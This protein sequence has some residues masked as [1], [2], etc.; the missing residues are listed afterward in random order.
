[1]TG[2]ITR[3]D[4]A[5][6]HATRSSVPWIAC[7]ALS[8]L[9]VLSGLAL[10][11]GAPGPVRPNLLLVTVDSLRGDRLACYGG[12][13][14]VGTVVCGL[15]KHGT[16]Y[17]WAIS[18]SPFTSVAIASI[19]TSSY[20]S[21]HGM[22][23]TASS[24]LR[25]PA[26]TLAEALHSGGYVSGAFVGNPSLNRSS[27]LQQGFDL[28]DDRPAPGRTA[29]PDGQASSARHGA[30]ELTQAALAF[31]QKAEEAEQPWFVWVH[32][33]EARGPYRGVEGGSGDSPPARHAG[34]S[35]STALI[36]LAD[37][38]GRSGVPAYQLPATA[39]S[40]RLNPWPD[41]ES[42]DLLR[43]Y[44]AEI[45]GI[46][47]QIGLLIAG[48]DA[49]GRP[50][51]IVTA[52][53]GEALGE[54]D[55]W[56]AHGHSVALEQIWVPLVWRPPHELG[57]ASAERWDRVVHEPVSTLDIAPTL[58]T[59]AGLHPPAHFAGVSLDAGSG[60][61]SSATRRR[62]FAE[63]PLRA[64]VVTRGVYYARD[65]WPL[66]EPVRDPLRGGTLHA[67]PTRFARLGS[68]GKPT[69]YRLA[70]GAS[71]PEAVSDPGIAELE[72]TLAAFLSRSESG[73]SRERDAEP[74]SAQLNA[75][76]E[77]QTLQELQ[78]SQARRSRRS[79]GPAGSAD[80]S[81]PSVARAVALA[82]ALCLCACEA[83]RPD[84]VLVTLDTLRR[85]HVGLYGDTRGL[86]PQLDRLAESGL[87]HDA[88]FTTMPTTGPAHL[89]LF[90]GLYPSVIGAT[91]NAE[92]LPDRHATRELTSLL[93]A[94]GY[95]TAAFV[96]SWLAGSY[97][98]GLRG[99]AVYDEP[100][101]VLRSGSD[102]V[103]AALDWLAIEEPRPIFLWVHIYD[104]H[105][106]YG[107]T[108]QKRLGFPLDPRIYGWT[109][110][111]HFASG[112]VT[113]RMNGLYEDGVREADDELGRLL[114]GVRELR[115]QP[116]GQAPVIIVVSDHGESLGEH[117]AT[118][119]YSYD[120]GEFLDP[121]AVRIA[122][123]LAGPGIPAERSSGAVS[124]RD[125]YTTILETAGLGDAY[126][127]IEGRR[128]LRYT[129][130]APRIVEFER[131]SFS[132]PQPAMVEA[133]AGGASDGERI[134][135]AGP[136]GKPTSGAG[137][138]SDALL[139]AASSRAKQAALAARETPPDFAPDTIEALK[140][141][142]YAP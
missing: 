54:D 47:Q 76:P 53:H 111:A 62:I 59:A 24:G 22:T 73:G 130:A 122:L 113:K 14:G 60:P 10:A 79:L 132:E 107:D 30:A 128:D 141:L 134:V 120:H 5:P 29:S 124:I 67:I 43:G 3:T 106:P 40:E 32:Y 93:V 38:S 25:S 101:S 108:N 52:D 115:S 109:D 17:S 51:V 12:P 125:L 84:I 70:A 110:A 104:A 39:P 33:G 139:A 119:G 50:G 1:M 95:A 74:G 28:Y 4:T 97:G 45:R 136:D 18:P 142:G 85:D 58:L 49:I 8:A 89:S 133:H 114:A 103:D 34:T 71:G 65:R 2:A 15:A 140:A 16:R 46:D 55:Y 66:T 80:R 126:A 68:D 121:E 137:G 90:T 23:A 100:S 27:N 99:F 20:P 138:A 31:A 26:L 81:A 37:H 21:V 61:P 7:L 6:Q 131:R 98:M 56:F 135:I 69:P 13:D 9:L 72:A 11:C 127:T 112:E 48:L 92:P 123:V 35:R 78:K 91:R 86:T 129:S 44:D 87:A 64:A 42:R 88:A 83:P 63:H 57:A 77:L 116:P 36:R 94:G 102:A 118:R 105:A 75:T 96:T 19:L 82:T 117:V 41:I